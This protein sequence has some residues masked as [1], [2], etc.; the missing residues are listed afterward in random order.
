MLREKDII[1]QARDEIVREILQDPALTKEITDYV[2]ELNIPMAVSNY[3]DLRDP[4]ALIGNYV[5]NR[6]MI[7]QPD[8]TL[9]TKQPMGLEKWKKTKSLSSFLDPNSVEQKLIDVAAEVD[10]KINSQ[11]LNAGVNSAEIDKIFNIVDRYKNDLGKNV[12]A[13]GSEIGKNLFVTKSKAWNDLLVK[14][15]LKEAVDGDYDLIAY[16]PADV[17]IDRWNEKGLDQQYGV[18]V[19]SAFKRITGQTPSPFIRYDKRPDADEFGQQNWRYTGLNVDG[20]AVYVSPNFKR[21]ISDDPSKPD[22]SGEIE[23]GV[24][25]YASPVIDLRKT[26]KGQKDM[27]VKDFVKKKSLPLFSTAIAFG[28]GISALSPEL[29]ASEVDIKADVA[30]GEVMLDVL[31]GL[32]AP[33]ASGIAGLMQYKEQ[34]PQRVYEVLNNNPEAVAALASNVK[35]AREDVASGLNY[36]P[37]S[38]LARQASD[39]FKKGIVSMLEPVIDAAAPVVNYALDPES[40]YDERGLNLFPAAVQGGKF[41]YDKILGEPEREA[42]ISAME[43]I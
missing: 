39:E 2:L 21:F 22:G 26:M 34:L 17:H 36:E 23:Y 5:L 37:R 38:A 35:Q 28:S 25:Q 12:G 7:D 6:L 31:S 1:E 24:E 33:V 14:N 30:S 18:L 3:G 43:T 40:V 27:S 29:R 19:P 15:V 11:L 42:V 13:L 4:S 41:I 8:L 20:K 32:I 9:H 10:E 16:A